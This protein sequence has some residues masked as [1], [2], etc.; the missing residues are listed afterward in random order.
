MDIYKY[1]KS[2]EI[3]LKEIEDNFILESKKNVECVPGCPNCG[4]Y[5]NPITYKGLG[6]AWHDI[7]FCISCKRLMVTH[8][9]DTMGGQQGYTVLVFKSKE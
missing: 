7:S 8:S 1:L 6:G 5:I 3:P 4:Y 9:P 2:K